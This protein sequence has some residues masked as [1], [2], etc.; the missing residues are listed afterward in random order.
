MPNKKQYAILDTARVVAALL[1][2]A[3]HTS[4]LLSWSQEADFIL[5]RIMARF[6]VPFFLMLS[7]YFLQLDKPGK[8]L[9]K[10][11]L[12]YGASILLYLP[13][14]LYTGYFAKS[15]IG[16]IGKDILFN[17][18][19]YHLWYLPA[20]ILG[21][22]IAIFLIRRLGLRGALF[23]ACLLYIPGLLGDSYYGFAVRIPGAEA[24]YSIMFQLF[25]Y[26]RNG[27]FFAP[28]FLVL[29][30]YAARRPAMPSP[31]IY[32]GFTVCCLLL[33]SE[34]LLLH[35]FGV[36]RHDS[37]YL[38]LVPAVY[39]L[40]VLLAHFNQNGCKTKRSL[41]ML[42]YIL[43]PWCIVLVRGLAKAT[44]F[45][46]FLLDNSIVYFLAVSASSVCAALVCIAAKSWEKKSPPLD[47]SRAWIEVHTDALC[48]NVVQLQKCLPDMCRLMAVVKADAYGHGI[49]SVIPA[50]KKA[51]VQ[52]FA[53]ATLN[54][55]IALRQQNVSGDILI[56]GYTAPEAAAYIHKHRLT[57]TVLNADYA[58]ALDRQSI[59]IKVHLK[60]DTGMH[61][62]GIPY[63]TEK[64]I[65][66]LFQYKNL[67]VT[68][69]YSHLCVSDSLEAADTAFTKQQIERFLQLI[70][71]I[72]EKGLDPGMVHIQSTYGILN[73][74]G[75]PCSY[76]RAGIGL[77]GVL[78]QPGNT[79]QKVD[80]TPVLSLKARVAGIQNIPAG[81]TVGYGRT[82]QAQHNI[83]A[84][85]VSIG[86]ADGIPRNWR[87]G[88]V[89]IRGQAAPVIGRICMDQFM[90]DI[91]E[92][93]TVQPGDP[94]TIIGR[95]GSR[96]IRCEEFAAQCGTISN[97]ILSRLGPRL[98]RIN[99]KKTPH[100]E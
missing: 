37:M 47:D 89:L 9:K 46:G 57:Q 99:A 2:V 8:F 62:L 40:F 79:R 60:I 1:V 83:T 4:P 61:R 12:L 100:K 98:P 23:A 76:A 67:L 53:V 59:Q 13:L 51:G 35:R 27:I 16:D 81:E 21:T 66:P 97:D 34:G 68:G 32:C 70:R 38:F 31:R 26:T 5:T 19:F 72:K 80:L 20:V 50:L 54:E 71:K 49:R 69:M 6:A 52:A 36:Q 73:Y 96:E 39:L 75:L 63:H 82:Y 58:K 10:T 92:I 29:G 42:V 55:G 25:D 24:A 14:N 7:G 74:S 95:D 56:L 84:A 87:N 91:S 3:I 28:L 64:E 94:V 17:G 33:L 90:A 15:S 45:Q 48:Q 86:Y 11:A 77:Y 88:H 30:A 22:G 93:Q 18:T 43:H 65:L 44:G 78:S 41:S 85:V